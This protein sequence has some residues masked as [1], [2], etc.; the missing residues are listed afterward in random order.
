MR[1]S[2]SAETSTSSFAPPREMA[3][4][5]RTKEHRLRLQVLHEAVHRGHLD[6][7]QRPSAYFFDLDAIELNARNL[8]LSSFPHTALHTFAVKANPLIEILNLVRKTGL[9]LPETSSPAAGATLERGSIVIVP[10]VG[11]YTTSMFSRYN[12]RPFPACYGF[13]GSA[14][15]G[16]ELEV[17]RR[18]E[19]PRDLVRFWS[20]EP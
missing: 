11:A 18:E 19:D 2:A 5:A 3:R 9:A 4:Q 12:S 6:R 1:T 7:D 14:V 17:L 20:K 16:V 15:G 10:D 8:K 13:R